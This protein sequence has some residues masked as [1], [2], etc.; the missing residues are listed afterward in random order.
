M[1]KIFT[2]AIVALAAISL[3]AQRVKTIMHV[4]SNGGSVLDRRIEKVDS[5]TFETITLSSE[6]PTGAINGVFTIND[7]GDQVVFS[8]GNLQYNTA[9]DIWSFAEHQWDVIGTA[10][11][12]TGM[13]DLFSWGTGNNPTD[14]C[15]SKDLNKYVTFYDWGINPISNGGNQANQWRTLSSDEWTYIF[16]Y[17]PNAAVLFGLGKVNGVNGVILL[18]DN[19]SG[20][21][22]TPSSTVGLTAVTDRY[23][24]WRRTTDYYENNTYTATQWAEMEA[25][26]AIFFPVTGGA[27]ISDDQIKYSAPDESGMYWS[28][29]YKLTPGYP[30]TFNY[31]NS[32]GILSFDYF[33]L[34]PKSNITNYR[35]IS[36]RL[37]A[38]Y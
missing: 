23:Y 26:G 14:F 35:G 24:D 13:M 37:V 18:P 7:D 17:R 9:T 38:D 8:Q 31:P 2:L 10:N 29:T 28:S 33:E 3:N 12:T 30:S 15:D 20:T 25:S 19:W 16:C 21:G 22:F 6:I 34:N 32:A 27:Y 11:S 5:I 4:W 1:K 36:V